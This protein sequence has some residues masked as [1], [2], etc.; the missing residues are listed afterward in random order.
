MMKR[1]TTWL[2]CNL[3]KNQS[4]VMKPPNQRLMTNNLTPQYYMIP[5]RKKVGVCPFIFSDNPHDHS[6]DAIDNGSILSLS[7]FE[8]INP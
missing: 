8:G 3:R 1:A 5:S 4:L 6:K 2:G 7:S